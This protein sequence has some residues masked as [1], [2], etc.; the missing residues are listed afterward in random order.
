MSQVLVGYSQQHPARAKA[1]AGALL[2]P[3]HEVW[4][5]APHPRRLR[6][7]KEIGEALKNG[8]IR[9]TSCASRMSSPAQ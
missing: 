6:L 5:D 2:A 8:G 4:W 1:L 9:R 7:V 3:P